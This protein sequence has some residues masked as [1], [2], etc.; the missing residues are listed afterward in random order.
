MKREGD[1]EGEGGDGR[2]VRDGKIQG[3]G[4]IRGERGGIERGRE[5]GE[6]GILLKHNHRHLEKSRKVSLGM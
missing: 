2:T 3:E 6:K 4:V 5:E 1:R